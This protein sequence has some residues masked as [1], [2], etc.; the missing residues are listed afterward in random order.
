M[1]FL[2]WTWKT[3]ENSQIYDYKK[4]KHW[5]KNERGQEVKNMKFKVEDSLSH[6]WIKN[7]ILA[8]LNML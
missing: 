4:Y 2:L 6:C 3:K 7:S 5:A 8:V 1:Y